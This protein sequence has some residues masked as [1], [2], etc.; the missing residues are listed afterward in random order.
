MRNVLQIAIVVALVYVGIN[1]F[2]SDRRINVIPGVSSFK[3]LETN[4]KDSK[5]LLGKKISDKANTYIN[6][7]YDLS[8]ANL[9][10]NMMKRVGH[11][12]EGIEGLE[13][14]MDTIINEDEVK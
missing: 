11:N 5:N 13:I 12:P 6:E 7:H 4:I 9:Y 8:L 10:R 2:S 3:E 1:G 14:Y